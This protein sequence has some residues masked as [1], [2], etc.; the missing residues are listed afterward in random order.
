MIPSR[1]NVTEYANYIEVESRVKKFLSYLGVTDAKVTS[2]WRTSNPNSQHSDASAIDI[3]SDQLVLLLREQKSDIDW[4][5]SITEAITGDRNT[6]PFRQFI[7]EHHKDGM[8]TRKEANDR[9]PV[10]RTEVVKGKS[11]TKCFGS[12]MTVFHLSIYSDKFL[13]PVSK[14]KRV[15]HSLRYDTYGRVKAN[16]SMTAISVNGLANLRNA[17][18]KLS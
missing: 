9:Q 15:V 17:N 14:D 4:L 7:I 18:F 11:V 8:L 16:K 6:D 3:Q 13:K 1:T 5:S 10:I 12:N 2:A